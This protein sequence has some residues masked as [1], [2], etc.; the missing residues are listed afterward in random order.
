MEN[1][2]DRNGNTLT[3]EVKI[4]LNMLHVLVLFQVNKR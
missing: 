2:D 1:A 3:N 4:D